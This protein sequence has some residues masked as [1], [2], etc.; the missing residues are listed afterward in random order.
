MQHSTFLLTTSY[1]D[2][3]SKFKWTH[4]Q[5]RC[6]QFIQHLSQGSRAFRTNCRIVCG[7]NSLISEIV[8][9]IV[10]GQEIIRSTT[11]K[12]PPT[13]R[14]HGVIDNISTIGLAAKLYMCK[15]GCTC[16]SKRNRRG[17]I[18]CQKQLCNRKLMIHEKS[19]K[20]TLRN[21]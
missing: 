21:Q 19:N 3:A 18:R 6:L 14:Y 5:L 13:W 4:E 1:L 9:S 10:F 7:R 12:I 11:N 15:L 16:L 2:A 20:T 8:T 17:A